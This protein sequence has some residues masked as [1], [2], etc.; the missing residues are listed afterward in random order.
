MLRSCLWPALLRNAAA[1]MNRNVGEIRLFEVGHVFRPG[2]SPSDSLPDEPLRIAGVL[3]QTSERGAWTETGRK[4]DFYDIK[5]ILE[6]LLSAFGVEH[7]RFKPECGYPYHPSRSATVWLRQG[8]SNEEEMWGELGEIHL[9]AQRAFDLPQPA[10]I[11]EVSSNPLQRAMAD[12]PR[13]RALP[14]FP[15]TSRD[16]AVVIPEQVMVDSIQRA[17]LEEGAPLAQEAVVFDVHVGDPVPQDR[18]SV[19]FA[20]VYRSE[21]RTLTGEEVNEVHERIV[22]RLSREFQAQLR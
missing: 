17:I 13:F 2:P 3:S 14:R 10:M 9:D 19:A 20:L 8:P 7:A 12:T 16:L 4:R 11:F 1:N 22:S 5:G 18:K 21:E 15:P 6:H